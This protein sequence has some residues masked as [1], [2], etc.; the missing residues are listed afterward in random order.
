[1]FPKGRKKT[2]R[3]SRIARGDLTENEKETLH[4]YTIEKLNAQSI[5][6]ARGKHISGVYKTLKKL[7]QKGYIS[8]VELTGRKKA[9][10][11]SLEVEKKV[12]LWRYHALHFVIKPFYLYPRY[13]KVQKRL[14]NH[15]IPFR[16]W[17]V[18]LRPK[19]IEM[20]LR[21][22]HDFANVDLYEATRAAE[23]SF[24]RSLRELQERYGFEVF[25]EKKANIRLV[26]QHLARTN[27]P[28]ARA[29]KGDFLK[30]KGFDGKVWFTIDKSRGVFEHEFQHPYLAV[31]DAEVLQPFLNDVRKHP[32]LVSDVVVLLH[33]V[34]KSHLLL[35]KQVLELSKA[36]EG[37][38]LLLNFSTLKD[39]SD[40]VSSFQRPCY[41]G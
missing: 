20:Q 24:E 9:P 25:K 40:E 3:K 7:R 34:S 19:T 14:G 37:V 31:D 33:D 27:S 38:L 36:L 12:E 2:R 28:I 23:K 15:S 4:L 39:S 30:V 32:T 16:D 29:K 17:I 1:M 11:V 21:S 10:P 8:R 13:S 5:S 26:N 35:Q 22:L 18:K 41:V 6:L